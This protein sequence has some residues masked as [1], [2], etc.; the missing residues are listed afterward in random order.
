MEILHRDTK[1]VKLHRNKVISSELAN[2]K[3]IFN[4]VRSYKDI[5]ETERAR[6][7]GVSGANNRESGAISHNKGG[8]ER[9]GWRYGNHT[10][11]GGNVRRSTR[12]DHPVRG[13]RWRGEGDGAEGVGE[14]LGIP[15]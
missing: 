10:K 11:V 13:V 12:V 4:D 3:K 6:K 7:S 8:R 2:R 15:R 9:G 5:V 14:G 1:R